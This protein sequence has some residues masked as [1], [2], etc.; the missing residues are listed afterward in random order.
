MIVTLQVFALT[1]FALTKYSLTKY[2]EDPEDSSPAVLL[3]FM[4][5]V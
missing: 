3:V 2:N 4:F 5:E 1:F